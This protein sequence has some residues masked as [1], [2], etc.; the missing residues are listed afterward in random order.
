MRGKIMT[1]VLLLATMLAGCGQQATGQSGKTT[2]S[3]SNKVARHTKLTTSAQSSRRS[4]PTSKKATSSSKSA[5][6]SNRARVQRLLVGEDFSVS[7]I[8]YNG[9]PI[10]E[11]MDANEAPQ[12]SVHDY[13]FTVYFDSANAA[14]IK[15]VSALK[16]K[17]VVVSITDSTVTIEDRYRFPYTVTGDHVQFGTFTESNGQGGKLTY[18]LLDN[19]DH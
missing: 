3:S 17:K 9:K 16:P 7:P 6:Q 11:A 15:F 19:R 13:S 4:Q 5:T 18:R 10:N 8:Q 14:T 1:T 12:N 2:K